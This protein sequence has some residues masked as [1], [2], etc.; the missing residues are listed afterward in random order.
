MQLQIAKIFDT[1]I[2]FLPKST[3]HLGKKSFSEAFEGI[4]SK[5]KRPSDKQG[6]EYLF[7]L[8]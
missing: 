8:L 1:P 4:S 3:F 5:S 7:N 6:K 2:C